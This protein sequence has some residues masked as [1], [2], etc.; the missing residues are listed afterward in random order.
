[1]TDTPVQLFLN[2]AAARGRAARRARRINELL[3]GAG[4]HVEM[5]QSTAVGDLEEQVRRSVE[6]GSQ[7]IVVAGGDGSV[8]EA[9]NGI[10]RAGGGAALGVVPTGTGNDFAKA[11]GIPLDWEHATTLLADRIA[12]GERTRAIDV[13][14]MNE[15]YFANGA[16]IGLD[17]RVTRIARSYRLPIGD[18]VYLI[19]IFR[20]MLDGIAS[21]HMR[22]TTPSGVREGPITLANVANGDWIGG[23]FNIAPD[24][25]HD[26]GAF[27]LIIVDPVSRPRVLKLLPKLMAGS[28]LG[29]KEISH[30]RV[31]EVLIEADEPVESHLDGE[32]LAPLRRFE[33]SILPDAL[34]IL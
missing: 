8:H 23:M 31:T 14:R 33:I 1:M 30:E 28:H 18:L 22:I 12:A 5:Q 24:A 3:S 32:I 16:G 6:R 13:G 4:E 21:P 34:Q 25:R 29:E 26:D 27:D 7:R 20:T 17:A 9:V 19:A 15:R 10:M 2:P 11:A